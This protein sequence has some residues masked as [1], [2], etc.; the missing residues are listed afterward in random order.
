MKVLGID[1]EKFIIQDRLKD[2]NIDEVD[3]KVETNN[4]KFREN[5]VKILKEQKKL[6]KSTGWKDT[7]KS[8]K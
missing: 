3:I 8:L 1:K 6:N 5:K 7:R 4:E 2:F